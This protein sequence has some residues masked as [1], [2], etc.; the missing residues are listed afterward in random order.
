M[1]FLLIVELRIKQI[2]FF[3]GLDALQSY[4]F[5]V[6]DS[7]GCTTFGRKVDFLVPE[8]LDAFVTITK[9]TTSCFEVCD[10]TASVTASGA[11][12]PYTYSWINGS[13]ALIGGGQNIS[14]LCAGT[15]YIQVVPTSPAGPGTS[16]RD[17]LGLFDFS[18]GSSGWTLNV[19][20]SGTNQ[21]YVNDSLSGL[22]GAFTMPAGPGSAN[23]FLHI[24]SLEEPVYLFTSASIDT[25]LSPVINTIGHFDVDLSFNWIGTG[26]DGIDFGSV[27]YSIDGGITWIVI[28]GP[29]SGNFSGFNTWQTANFNSD[30][31]GDQLDNQAT[32][33]FMFTWENGASTPGAANSPF[34]VDDIV[35]S[36]QRST[37]SEITRTCPDVDTLTIFEPAD[38]TG[39]VAFTDETCD[40]DDGTIT[41]NVV[42]GKGALT[43]SLNGG[44]PQTS[45]VFT[46]LLPAVYRVTA[47]DATTCEKNID[48]VTI[49]ATDTISYTVNSTD[50]SCGNTNDGTITVTAS[51]GSGPLELSI[52]NESPGSYNTTFSHTGLSASTYKL[53]VRDS[54]FVASGTGCRTEIGE[55]VL[56]VPVT[57]ALTATAD[58]VTCNG[59]CNGASR[60]AISGAFPTGYGFT[61]QWYNGSG[62]AIANTD[63]LGMKDLCAGTYSVEVV[64]VPLVGASCSSRDTTM[65]GEPTSLDTT[66]VVYTNKTS[67]VL[68]DGSIVIT[69]TGGNSPYIYSVD[70]GVG[71]LPTSSF[72]ALDNDIYKVLIR[73]NKNCT[74]YAGQYTVFDPTDL[75]FDSARA[76]NI[77]CFGDSTGTISIHATGTNLPIEYSIDGSTYFDSS[78]V[79]NGL[80]PNNYTIRLRDAGSCTTTGT[81][82]TI[83]QPQAIAVQVI[84][85]TATNCYNTADGMIN[86]TA[87]GGTGSPY[88]F[89]R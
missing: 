34:G 68:D 14:T 26:V 71:Y 43:Y 55:V 15:N 20:S 10:G 82:V 72:T 35:I 64:T 84:N 57:P 39:T 29:T 61:Y 62:T 86:I 47:H 44:T 75:A 13:L 78:N 1:S 11:T 67:C 65:V 63:S 2:L 53:W 60:V 19:G 12:L 42:G 81:T 54:A 40:G 21:W 23:D 56:A 37:I 6:K 24:G 80:K 16:T 70:S 89:Y 79:V 18:G 58:S 50:I 83:S 41:V 36:S 22:A 49:G 69:A 48:T 32:L 52:T 59:D 88:L 7:L 28:A 76:T 38:I 74:F 66:S 46:G 33:Q 27:L 30:I 3:N 5:V 51:G 77:L 25:A 4:Y 87:L 8:V 85:A 73:D 17:T 45:N 9:D 31:F